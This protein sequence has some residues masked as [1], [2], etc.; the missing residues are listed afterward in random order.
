MKTTRLKGQFIRAIL[1]TI[2]I[3]MAVWTFQKLPI[4]EATVINFTSPFLVL[5]MAYP[6]LGEKVGPYR[7][8][9]TLF[10]FIGVIVVI[11]FDSTILTPEN[12]MIAFGWVFANSL[13]LIML[14][15]LGKSEHAITT[16]F[17]FSY[18][19][20]GYNIT[21]PTLC[22]SNYAVKHLLHMVHIR[23]RDCWFTITM[24]KN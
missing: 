6:L 9:A 10:G 15:Q 21:I 24:A 11:G 16:V 3:V 23:D 8:L 4:T 7:I 2:G 18:H 22:R 5:I 14:R 20:F 13:V 19:W 12:L 17:L 1:G